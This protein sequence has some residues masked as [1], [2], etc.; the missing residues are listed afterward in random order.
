MQLPINARKQKQ[1]VKIC[2]EP[3]CGL[4]FLGLSMSKYCEV[5]RNSQKR[6]RIKKVYENVAIKNQSF[7]HNF[8]EVTNV[9][10]TC[11]ISGCNRK[12][13]VKVFP[14]QSVYPKYCEDHRNEFK[15]NNFIRL[16]RNKLT[17]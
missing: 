3:G 14:K 5:H 13:I 8:N 6:K 16:Q 10:F 12:Y 15:R 9:E 4:E 2:Q 7:D 1:K 11:Q 17:K